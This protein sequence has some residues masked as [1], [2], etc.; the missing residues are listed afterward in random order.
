MFDEPTTPGW[1]PPPPP[2]PRHGVAIAAL[3]IALV[4]ALGGGAAGWFAWHR[5][6][7]DA[8]DL[9]R[10]EA[11]RSA[12]SATTTTT[13]TTT[14]APSDNPLGALGDFGNL[15]GGNAAQ[16]AECFAGDVGSLLGGNRVTLPNDSARTQYDAIVT[17][18]QRDRKL[19]FKK[20]P[21][22]VYV[23][24]AE[25]ARRVRAQILHDYTQ[26]KAQKDEA[27]LVALGVI[28]PGTNLREEYSKFV[29]GQVAGYYD[30]AT[31][32][33]VILGN[34]DRPLDTNELTTVAHELEHALADQQLGLP[35]AAEATSAQGSDAQLAATSLVEGDATFTMTEFQLQALDIGGLLSLGGGDVSGQLQALNDAP[36]YLAS[37]LL[38]PYTEGLGFVCGLHTDGG[39]SAVDRAYKKPP[40]TTAQI[41]FHDRYTNGERAQR[42]PAPSSP[43]ADW[44]KVRTETFGAADLMFLFE[45]PGNDTSKALSNPRDRAAA[46]AGGTITQWARK[47]STAV[48]VSLVEH[49]HSGPSLCDSM[50]AWATATPP[51]SGNSSHTVQCS[52]ADVRVVLAS[53]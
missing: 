18:V 13:P 44:R 5:A 6:R 53:G 24:A 15:L 3:A 20:V 42:P 9:R 23:N 46:W 16:L 50:R 32:D 51:A 8:N 11:Q 10:T 39:W 4:V 19:T 37:E 48:T 12:P 30:P 1:A 34:A 41:M 33:M 35:K 21:T 49:Q 28:A 29:G 27:L 38:F 36:H 25:M 52:G 22:P 26:A 45:A 7:D 14:T 47:S 43:G 2:R 31:G 40:T 17:W